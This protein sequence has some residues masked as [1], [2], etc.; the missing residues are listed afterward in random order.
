MQINGI[1]EKDNRIV[2]LL[3]ANARMTYS[4]IG[5]Q[6]GL[7]RTAVKAR[8]S[9]LERSGVIK[10][11]R[12]V[13]DPLDSAGTMTFVV[14][15]E[16]KP[17]HFEEARRRFARSPETV[18]LLQTTGSCHLLAVCVSESIQT[19]KVFVNAVY[20]SVPGILSINAHSVLEV[21]KGSFIPE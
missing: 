18:V 3:R 12:A 8:V 21:I 7:S 19:M 1:D 17:E 16:T 11:Y 4:E 10:G 15:I 20:K 14:N 5:G 9:A 13:T 2:G 6:V